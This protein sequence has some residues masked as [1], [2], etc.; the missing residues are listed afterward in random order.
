MPTTPPEDEQS[1]SP[2]STPEERLAT[3]SVRDES[4]SP[5]SEGNVHTFV[6]GAYIADWIKN[7]MFA[8]LLVV[9]L[10]LTAIAGLLGYCSRSANRQQ[11]QTAGNSESRTQ[12]NSH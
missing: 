7:H 12:S 8:A 3:S 11:S 2:G 6:R 1:I 4:P 5:T 10:L 9:I